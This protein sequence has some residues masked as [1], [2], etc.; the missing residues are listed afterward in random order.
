MDLDPK[1][2]HYFISRYMY[3][4]GLINSGKNYKEANKEAIF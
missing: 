3:E 4:A 2:Y 1:E